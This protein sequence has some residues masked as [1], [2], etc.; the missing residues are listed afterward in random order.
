M[1]RDACDVRLR[2]ESTA[3]THMLS[4]KRRSPRNEKPNGVGI[5]SAAR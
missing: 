5:Y 3:A 4:L 1:T 2:S